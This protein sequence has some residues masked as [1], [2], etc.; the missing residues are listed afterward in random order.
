M[1]LI[2]RTGACRSARRAEPQGAACH[3]SFVRWSPLPSPGQP[4]CNPQKS[5]NATVRLRADC[6]PVNAGSFFAINVFFSTT[7]FGNP[8]RA[9]GGGAS[10]RISGSR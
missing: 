5:A 4:E 7:Y 9:Y 8:S 6:Q 3:A 1:R 2:V 10:P